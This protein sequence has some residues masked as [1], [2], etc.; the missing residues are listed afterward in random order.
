LTRDPDSE[1]QRTRAGIDAWF[2]RYFG[3]ARVSKRMLDSWEP[4]SKRKTG[5]R[6]IRLLTRAAPSLLPMAFAKRVRLHPQSGGP[7]EAPKIGACKWVPA[8]RRDQ[9]RIPTQDG[10]C[11]HAAV[12]ELRRP[13]VP[14]ARRDQC[15]IPTQDGCCHHTAVAELRRPLVPA[16]GR[17]PLARPAQGMPRIGSRGNS[18]AFSSLTAGGG[19]LP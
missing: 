8:A 14:A 19:G 16:G 17:D 9:C 2:R 1:N 15:R 7:Q 6:Y 18:R 3:A 13:L 11:H 5:L 4:G 12:A 10:C